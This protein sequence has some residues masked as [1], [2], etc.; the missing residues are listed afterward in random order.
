[1]W[2]IPLLLLILLLIAILLQVDFVF[3]LVYV[4][5]GSYLL[6][7]W[8]TGRSLPR[9]QVR[10]RLTD[11]I[12]PGE[13]TR[14]E[15]EIKNTSWWPVPWLRL[16][17]SAPLAVAAGPAVRQVVSLGPKGRLAVHY[18]LIGRQRG[19]Y[20]IGPA[21]MTVGDLF[22]FAEVQGRLEALDH[23][24]VYPRVI[25]LTHVD[26]TSRS[27]HGSLASQQRIFA[28]PTRVIGKREYRPGDPLRTIDW[29]SSAH[30]NALQVK[31]YA[32]AVSLIGVIFLEL[33]A[34]AYTTQLRY[35]ASEWG[36]VVAASL[37]SYLIE[38]RQAVGLGCN[39]V[40][41]LSGVERW[42]IPPRPG[43]VHLMKLLEWLARVQ[44][45]DLAPLADWLPTAALGLG[46]G[47]TVIIVCPTG[48]EATCRAAHRLLRAGLNP[49]LAVIEPHGQFGVIRER[50]RRLGVAAHLV[51][52]E[53]DLKRWAVGRSFSLAA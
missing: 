42:L 9:L 4:L 24:T 22:G 1:M 40:D 46:W 43:R 10:R 26:L 51:A 23:L 3:Y 15:I 19:Y 33:S 21:A 28:D 31:Q 52:S 8:W 41:T 5:A 20:P 13:T 27:P 29:K 38:Q 45:A 47:T 53:A 2:E 36:I 30:T 49:V 48:D 37:A 35:G 44:T 17:E 50:A 7:R 25:P 14:V 11:H 39:G 18:D 16:E 34:R 6:A 32:P 12:F